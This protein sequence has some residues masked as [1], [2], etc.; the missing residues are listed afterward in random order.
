MLSDDVTRKVRA[1]LDRA[2]HPGTPQA[3]TEAA[4][5][6]AYRL[7]AKYD[8]DE[9]LLASQQVAIPSWATCNHKRCTQ[10]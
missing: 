9:R 3:E 8:L 1:L 6:M 5:A 7:M 10:A 2:N 4:L